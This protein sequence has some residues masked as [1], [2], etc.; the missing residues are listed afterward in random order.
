MTPWEGT[1]GCHNHPTTQD[2]VTNLLSFNMDAWQFIAGLS[3][4]SNLL[5]DKCCHV[6]AECLI[7]SQ[8]AHNHGVD[9]SNM[10]CPPEESLDHQLAWQ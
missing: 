10:A 1:P 7:N 8:E 4:H 2:D 9:F 5:S 6:T 3:C